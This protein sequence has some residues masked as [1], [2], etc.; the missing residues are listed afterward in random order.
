MNRKRRI[1]AFKQAIRDRRIR[2]LN[3][4]IANP[5]ASEKLKLAAEKELISYLKG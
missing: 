3:R 1:K 4:V 2:E 5:R